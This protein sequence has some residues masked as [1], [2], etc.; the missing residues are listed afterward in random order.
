[1]RRPKTELLAE[2]KSGSL[3]QTTLLRPFAITLFAILGE[4]I[5]QHGLQHPLSIQ[6]ILLKFPWRAERIKP[7]GHAEAGKLPRP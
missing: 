6:S 3:F 2:P 5:L 7:T 4:S 1:M